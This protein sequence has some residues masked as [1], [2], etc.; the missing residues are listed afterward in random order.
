[1]A[2]FESVLETARQL[3]LE[4]RWKLIDALWESVPTEAEI[5]LHAD[6]APE[7]EQRVAAIRAGTATSVPWIVIREEA[8]KRLGRGSYG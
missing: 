2:D 7:L 6:W 1:M 5:P 4:D 8:L 3:S